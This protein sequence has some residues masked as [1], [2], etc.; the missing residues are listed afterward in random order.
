[1]KF[2][3]KEFEDSINDYKNSLDYTR[4]KSLNVNPEFYF[5]DELLRDYGLIKYVYDLESDSDILYVNSDFLNGKSPLYDINMYVYIVEQGKNKE[6]DCR[7]FINLSDYSPYCKCETKLDNVILK[8]SSI[9]QVRDLNISNSYLVYSSEKEDILSYYKLEP[10]IY[11]R[12]YIENNNKLIIKNFFL[13]IYDWNTFDTYINIQSL[14]SSGDL[15]IKNPLLLFDFASDM[16]YNI[17]Y[18]GYNDILNLIESVLEENKNNFRIAFINC[19]NDKYGELVQL[20]NKQKIHLPFY[21]YD[22]DDIFEN[23]YNVNFL[24]FFDD[25][26]AKIIS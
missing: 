23:K 18:R 8:F 15:K 7:K 1:M 22:L 2:T 5:E 12:K 4:F 10:L 14:C 9:S 26:K 21:A 6:V 13:F 16:L 11:N 17:E 19:C 25:T 3:K 24:T 20:L